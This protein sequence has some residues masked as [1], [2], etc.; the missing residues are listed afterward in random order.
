MICIHGVQSVV[1]RTA[2]DNTPPPNEHKQREEQWCYEE[3]E[4]QEEQ[5][6]ALFDSLAQTFLQVSGEGLIDT[7]AQQPPP[8]PKK[9][10]RPT[11]PALSLFLTLSLSHTQIETQ[12]YIS[13]V[14]SDFRHAL[15]ALFSLPPPEEEEEEQEEAGV[16]IL[17][18]L[19][20]GRGEEEGVIGGI[21]KAA[22]PEALIRLVRDQCEVRLVCVCGEEGWMQGRCITLVTHHKHVSSLSSHTQNRPSTLSFFACSYTLSLTNTHTH[23]KQTFLQ[24][25]DDPCTQQRAIL[26][27]L[28]TLS[29][30]RSQLS[31]LLLPPPPPPSLHDTNTDTGSQ[32]TGGGGRTPSPICL[33]LV[34]LANDRARVAAALQSLGSAVH[35]R[36]LQQQQPQQQQQ[37]PQEEEEAE[38]GAVLLA[39]FATEAA[40]FARLGRQSL[41]SLAE[42][43]LGD[44][45]FSTVAAGSQQHHSHQNENGGG[46]GQ[47]LQQLFFATR[48]A[49]AW[50]SS[51]SSSSSPID[52]HLAPYLL[53]LL[54]SIRPRFS[55]PKSF[56]RLLSLL[57]ARSVNA[58]THMHAHIHT[59]HIHTYT[60]AYTRIRI[61]T[62]TYIHTHTSPA[63]SSS[64]SKASCGHRRRG[65]CCY[66]LLQGRGRGQEG[67]M[68]KR[69]WMRGSAIRCCRSG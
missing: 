64:T 26:A 43:L 69:S 8:P 66:L 34:G 54:P 5:V 57:L 48:L 59:P 14:Q 17:L 23:S 58:H 52:T 36:L 3:E 22:W 1:E 60:H 47:Q 10:L 12:D 18:R 15:H 29:D 67:G 45:L 68:R 25:L 30:C 46:Q 11:T 13:H 40:A 24:H 62:H 49:H 65:R 56:G 16:H 2:A 42:W 51:S 61:K 21:V 4:E 35:A 63:S 44:A 19:Y 28:S 7:D 50:S 9:I 53:A 33:A 6:K 37:Q 20:A 27:L 55:D 38:Q 41:R 32:E 39:A 31:L